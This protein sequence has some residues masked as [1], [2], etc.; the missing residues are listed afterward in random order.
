[1]FRKLL[2]V[3]VP[4]LMFSCGNKEKKDDPLLV[5]AP[6]IGKVE[7]LYK[8]YCDEDFETYI[9]HILS[10]Q[11]KSEAYRTQVINML[12]QQMQLAVEDHLGILK[13]TVTRVEQS[14]AH[15]LYADAYLLLNYGDN[16]SEQTV[17]PLVY[18]NGKW[19]IK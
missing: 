3:I 14:K 16:T 8:P 5:K 10:V 12:K 4:A 11:D 19:W 9:G 13:V 18:Q 6:S 15:P 7:K 2:L 17:L 1:M